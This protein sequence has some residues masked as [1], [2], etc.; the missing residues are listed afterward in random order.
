MGLNTFLQFI[1]IKGWSQC[2]FPCFGYTL[3]SIKSLG[4]SDVL[5]KLCDKQNQHV[6]ERVR[7]YSISM[8]HL[9][10]ESRL[11]QGNSRKASFFR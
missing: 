7:N 8:T 4:T 6:A 1:S 3:R 9:T 5:L 11:A 10:V 2:R